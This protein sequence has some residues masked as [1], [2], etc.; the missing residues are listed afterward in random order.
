M[1]TFYMYFADV[2]PDEPLGETECCG[3]NL[4]NVY[5]V[6]DQIE[7]YYDS[8]K[9]AVEQCEA[10]DYFVYIYIAGSKWLRSIESVL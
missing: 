5:S 9:F 8:G 7:I 4:F 3:F 1:V 2:P 6:A 10:K